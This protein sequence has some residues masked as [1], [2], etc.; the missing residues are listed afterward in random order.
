MCQPSVVL[1]EE[2]LQ[3]YEYQKLK[4]CEIITCAV[5]IQLYK[6]LVKLSPIYTLILV[7]RKR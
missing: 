4:V 5:I 7:V 3:T 1:Y 2:K 6:I